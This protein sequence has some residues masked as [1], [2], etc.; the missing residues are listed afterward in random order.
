MS[1]QFVK[2]KLWKCRPVETQEN[3]NQVS[4]ASHRPWKTLPVFHFP[5]ASTNPILM[6]NPKRKDPNLTRPH[7]LPSG[8]FLDENMLLLAKD[9]LAQQFS[10]PHHVH[11]T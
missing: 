10:G 7:Y 6:P 1:S 3:Q 9:I 11:I 4:L 2:I 5:T 8:S